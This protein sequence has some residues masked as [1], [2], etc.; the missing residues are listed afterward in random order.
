MSILPCLF[1]Y[2]T[3]P[4]LAFVEVG[5]FNAFFSLKL[6]LRCGWFYGGLFEFRSFSDQFFIL[7]L[8]I[9]AFILLIGQLIVLEGF[10]FLKGGFFCFWAFVFGEFFVCR[11]FCEIWKKFRLFNLL[12]VRKVQEIPRYTCICIPECNFNWT[13]A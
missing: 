3:R 13:L 8:S 2:F 12:E 1:F 7:F 9:V 5:S 4:S 11:I 6:H 10:C